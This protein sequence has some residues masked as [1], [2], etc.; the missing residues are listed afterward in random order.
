MCVPLSHFKQGKFACRRYLLSVGQTAVFHLNIIWYCDETTFTLI[1]FLKVDQIRYLNL[2]NGRP[3]W[4]A[5][6]YVSTH[7]W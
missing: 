6:V 5:L 1:G 2:V 7:F 4:N 3:R